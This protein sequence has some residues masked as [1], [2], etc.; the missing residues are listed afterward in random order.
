MSEQRPEAP[1][2]QLAR[3]APRLGLLIPSI[4]A[5]SP[6]LALMAAVNAGIGVDSA[7]LFALLYFATLPATVAGLY[8]INSLSVQA[9]RLCGGK[10]DKA[11]IVI[12]VLPLGFLLPQ[13]QLLSLIGRC[14][15]AKD[16]V[17]PGFL[18]LDLLVNVLTFGAVTILYGLLLERSLS[19][20]AG[21][22]R[23]EE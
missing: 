22:V 6:T 17:R 23:A 18:P 20:L 7:Q 16:K 14:N 4:F 12:G 10:P 15:D 13:Y 2:M 11:V 21:E 19:L 5:A 1:G 8:V 9:A 3:R